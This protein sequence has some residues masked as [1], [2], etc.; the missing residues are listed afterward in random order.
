M[1]A[2]TYEERHRLIYSPYPPYYNSFL[3]TGLKAINRDLLT[4]LHRLTPSE[5]QEFIP[6]SF[7]SD[8]DAGPEDVWR[9]SHDTSTPNEFVNCARHKKLREW[10]YVMWDRL[11]L[12]QRDVFRYPWQPM[13]QSVQGRTAE[14]SAGVDREADLRASQ[15]RRSIIHLA[16][17]RGYWDE[18]DEGKVVW[19]EGSAASPWDDAK[20]R[21]DCV[22]CLGSVWCAP[23]RL[24]LKIKERTE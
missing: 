8:P 15:A 4:Q 18:E 24:V 10:G 6:N 17:G 3:N 13:L 14:R 5:Q 2:S 9:W 21:R 7:F 19:L 11:H 20:K 12:D 1:K 23:H 16:G 22:F